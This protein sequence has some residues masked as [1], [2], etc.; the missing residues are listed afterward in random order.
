[1][2]RNR[3]VLMQQMTAMHTHR[4]IDD[5]PAME[6]CTGNV[7][8]D[9]NAMVIDPQHHRERTID[10]D[11][12]VDFTGLRS[13]LNTGWHC[14]GFALGT[15]WYAYNNNNND[16]G[17]RHRYGRVG[18]SSAAVNGVGILFF[19]LFFVLAG[20]FMTALSSRP[21]INIIGPISIGCGAFLTFLALFIYLYRRRHIRSD[22]RHTPIPRQCQARLPN[23]T[24]ETTS[25]G[26]FPPAYTESGQLAMP[27]SPPEYVSYHPPDY[28]DDDQKNGF[29]PPSYDEATKPSIV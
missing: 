19:A 10:I 23:V 18:I 20:V 8:G 24:I 3:V 16:D 15:F 14:R 5:G 13:S 29:S 26:Q 1:M 11:D 22:S 4:N 2:A 7:Y 12:D 21:P 25:N 28:Y 17:M 9:S 6:R 27:V